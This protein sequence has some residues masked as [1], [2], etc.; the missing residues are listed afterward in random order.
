MKRKSE[1]R[2]SA[3]AKA[4]ADEEGERLEVNGES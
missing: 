3:A 4:M 2:L 1:N